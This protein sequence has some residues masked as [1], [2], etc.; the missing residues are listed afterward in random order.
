[1][2]ASS[3]AKTPSITSAWTCTLRLSA[4]P[5]RWTIATAPPRP[6]VTPSSRAR[7]RSHPGTARMVTATTARH[8]SW[9]QASW[10]RTRCGTLNTHC[11]TGTSGKTSSTRCAARSVIRRPPQLGQKPRPLHEHA[12]SR[13]SPHPAHRNRTNPPARKP[14]RRN[15]RN[16]CSTNRGS[17]SPSR[18]HAACA[19]K[20]SNWFRTI[21]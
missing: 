2:P 5:N 3:L 11:R 8:R 13:S 10:Y 16:S 19:R 20:V 15:A 12:A 1:M 21:R 14:H 6:S 4:P 7:R 18:S 9:S 17:P